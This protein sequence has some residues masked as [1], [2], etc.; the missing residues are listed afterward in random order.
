MALVSTAIR[1]SFHSW[2]GGQESTRVRLLHLA[3]L[4]RLADRR[5]CLLIPRALRRARMKAVARDALA[6]KRDAGFSRQEFNRRPC[7]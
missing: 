3:E 2:F 6:M 5:N 4:F 7:H 1:T